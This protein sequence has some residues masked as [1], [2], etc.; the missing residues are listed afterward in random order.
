VRKR[1]RDGL[2]LCGSAA[3][4]SEYELINVRTLYNQLDREGRLNLGPKLIRLVAGARETFLAYSKDVDD[5]A[6]EALAARRRHT[7]LLLDLRRER[8]FNSHII[9]AA[10][11]ALPAAHQNV[12]FATF[13]TLH[14]AMRSGFASVPRDLTTVRHLGFD[15]VQR[16]VAEAVSLADFC[17]AC[18]LAMRALQPPATSHY[19]TDG[20]VD[21]EF[22]SF[23]VYTLQHDTE[24]LLSCAPAYV[25]S[26]SLDYVEARFV[27]ANDSAMWPWLRGPVTHVAHS[28]SD[29]SMQSVAH[30]AAA[31]RVA[32]SHPLAWSTA[33]H[34]RVMRPWAVRA[35]Q[36]FLK[37]LASHPQGRLLC[38]DV[39]ETILKRLSECGTASGSYWRFL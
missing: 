31:E 33:T 30:M 37:C 20:Q 38:W 27:G 39:V 24:S 35:V 15:T 28:A 3:C 6:R 19:R 4:R 32:W 16:F 34:L 13:P 29:H 7:R 2:R 12:C 22:V 23:V 10:M 8:H 25:R 17:R 18:W 9:K 21:R 36:E 5:V 14:S 11:S 26:V 1:R